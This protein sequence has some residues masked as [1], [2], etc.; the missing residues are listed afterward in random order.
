VLGAGGVIVPP[1]DYY[2]TI[3]DILRRHEILL[4]ADEVIC[5]FGRTGKWFGCQAFGFTPDMLSIAKGLSAGYMPIGGVLIAPHVFAAIAKESHKNCLFS[6]GFTYSGHPVASAV[7]SEAL[8]I[9]S[10]IDLPA[11]AR[12]LGAHLRRRLDTIREHPLVGD[13]RSLGFLAGIELMADRE[14]RIPFPPE[15]K[16]GA[17]IERRPANM[18]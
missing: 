1:A 11:V 7:A 6:H 14:R 9:Y 12:R 2:K 17:A 18:V 4:L 10:E 8:R 16:P 13:V 5:G 15:R 3:A